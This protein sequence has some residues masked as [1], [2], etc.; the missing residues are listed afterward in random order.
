M[1]G[2]F[3]RCQYLQIA[4]AAEFVDTFDLKYNTRAGDL[5]SQL[6]G[7]QKQ[8]IAIARCDHCRGRARRRLMMVFRTVCSVVL[9]CVSSFVCC[10]SAVIRRP[11]MFLF[12]EATSALDSTSERL[13]QVSLRWGR[14]CQQ[15]CVAAR[16]RH[17]CVCTRPASR[18]IHLCMHPPPPVID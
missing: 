2:V 6:S 10:V 1:I 8:R 15:L 9:G 13:V 3:R 12:D 11:S 4:N 17:E 16:V 5:G 18:G 7:G 14:V